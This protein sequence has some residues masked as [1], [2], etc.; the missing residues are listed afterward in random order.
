[1]SKDQDP[2][3]SRYR[4]TKK[5]KE[6][7]GDTYIGDGVFASWDGYNIKLYTIRDDGIPHIIFINQ[8]NV[9]ELIKYIKSIYVMEILK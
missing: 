2:K 3:F 9:L 8:D 4:T 1:M 7:N 6:T 5:S